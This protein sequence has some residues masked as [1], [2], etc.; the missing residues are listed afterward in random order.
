MEY[1]IQPSPRKVGIYNQQEFSLSDKPL[2]RA[3]QSA[4]DT[5][6]GFWI[7]IEASTAKFSFGN[8]GGDKITW[9]GSV[10]TITGTLVSTVTIS[11][12]AIV[13]QNVSSVTISTSVFY[14]ANVSTTTVSTNNIYVNTGIIVGAASSDAL[15]F[16]SSGRFYGA[17]LHNN[18]SGVT[19]STNQ[20]VASGKYSPTLSSI[21]N[22][23]GATTYQAQW[24]RVGNVVSVSGKTDVNPTLTA[25]VTRL[26][27]TLPIASA[28]VNEE[29]CAGSAAASGIAGQSAAIRAE[30]TNDQ[31]E[32]VWIAGD[33]TV[34]PM[35]YSYQY[36]MR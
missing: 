13:A 21:A 33:I 9:D 32:M 15:I 24:L 30:P 16:D 1:E 25:T 23:D 18:A 7:G 35:F 5:G 10:L 19:G 28:L 6:T 11:T 20:Y 12:A 2:I 31:S 34:Q 22:L 29:D 3:G 17:A 14:G 8:S 36:E 27:F 26:G 4:F